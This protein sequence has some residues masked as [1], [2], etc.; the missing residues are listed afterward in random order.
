MASSKHTRACSASFPGVAASSSPVR[1]RPGPGTSL[2]GRE[3]HDGRRPLFASCL[4]QTLLVTWEAFGRR[5]TWG[6]DGVCREYTM[7]GCVI[8]RLSRYWLPCGLGNQQSPDFHLASAM[9]KSLLEDGLRHHAVRGQDNPAS[10]PTRHSSAHRCA[11][12]YLN[13]NKSHAQ[14]RCET[15]SEWANTLPTTVVPVPRCSAIDCHGMTRTRR[16]PIY[17]NAVISFLSV[18]PMTL[19][20]P[21]WRWAFSCRRGRQDS[22]S[23]QTS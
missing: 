10:M 18:K 3:V 7:A 2:H 14:H 17:E 8:E 20:R 13:I 5:E 21:A 9:R 22:Y 19:C 16:H 4:W 6:T 23:P 15:V 12:S 1:G 11:G